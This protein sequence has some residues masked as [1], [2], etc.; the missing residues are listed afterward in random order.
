MGDVLAIARSV[1]ARTPRP[2]QARSVSVPPKRAP[3]Q[4]RPMPSIADSRL[5]RKRLI[6]VFTVVETGGTVQALTAAVCALIEVCDSEQGYTDPA[7]PFADVALVVL[8]R[9]S[10]L[11]HG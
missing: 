11:S 9:C 8:G 2:Q 10:P 5:A 3:L 6:V 4:P 1:I 7:D